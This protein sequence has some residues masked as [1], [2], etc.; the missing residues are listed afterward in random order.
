MRRTTLV[1]AAVALAATAAPAFAAPAATLSLAEGGTSVFNWTGGPGNGV[2]SK[3]DGF[4]GVGQVKCG[5]PTADCADTLIKVDD[6]GDLTFDLHGDSGLLDQA[7]D[8]TGNVRD[9][10]DA[11]LFRSD[12]S[13][14]VGEQLASSEGAGHDE[15]VLVSAIEPGYYVARVA[16]YESVQGTFKASAKLTP[17]VPEPEEEE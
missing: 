5:D 2:L 6:L 3:V 11:Y 8:P 10:L 14:T 16:F 12:A 17:F 15:Q 13:G 9:D 1:A 7:A 4:A